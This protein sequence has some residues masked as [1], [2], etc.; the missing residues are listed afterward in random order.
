M[1]ANPW[2]F[3]FGTILVLVLYWSLPASRAVARQK[4]LLW[5]SAI[6]VLLYSP[7]GFVCCLV[8]VLVPMVAQAVYQRFKNIYVF[9]VFIALAITP[10]IFLRLFTEQEFIISFGV[11]FATIK[12][13]GLVFT[14]YAGRLQLKFLDTAL[15]IYFFPLFTIGPVERYQFFK[16]GNFDN[17]LYFQEALHGIYRITT[18]LFTIMF[19]CNTILLPLRSDYYGQT[20]EAISEFSRL[21][22]MGFILVSFL[23]TYL[24]FEGFSSISIGLSRLFGLKVI[25]NFDRP[26]LVSNLMDFWKR[27]HISMGNWINQFIFFPIV[28]WL[29]TRDWAIYAGTIA[30]FILFG[31]WHAFTLNYL[32]WGIGNGI[33]VAGIQ[34]CVSNKIFPLIKKPGFLKSVSKIGGGMLTILY[35]AWLQTFA[36]LSDFQTALAL[37]SKLILG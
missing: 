37:S 36:N 30:A 14:A 16:A 5:A 33:V 15:M 26:L 13:I 10:L 4:V 11:A 25:E 27:Y 8:L 6:M 2:L 23:F 7:G 28:L 24:N 31:M 3:F 21:D 1:L 34:F 29:R 19:I 32:V 18:G 22:S 12:S 35:I 20:F 9:W 17:K